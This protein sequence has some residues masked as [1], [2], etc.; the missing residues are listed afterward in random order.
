[1][2]WYIL[3]GVLLLGFGYT[4]AGVLCFA[5]DLALIF[6]CKCMLLLFFAFLLEDVF[7]LVDLLY[8]AV[9]R[10]PRFCLIFLAYSLKLKCFFEK[11]G[12][13]RVMKWCTS[14]EKKHMH[15]RKL[16]I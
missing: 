16:P 7:A 8:F 2:G 1:M 15:I 11:F 13:C 14:S 3:S 12:L 6:G 5:F 4:K 10:C 9:P